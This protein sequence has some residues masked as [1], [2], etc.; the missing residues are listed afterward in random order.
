MKLFM[1]Y[2][3]GAAGNSNIEV[4]DIRFVAGN[5]ITDT[6]QTLRTNWFGHQKGLHID[7]YVEITNIDGYQVSLVAD[8]P[9]TDQRLYFVNL[10]GYKDSSLAE[11]HEFGLFVA[12]NKTEAKQR[13]KE[14]LL[15][16]T[17][18]QHK[19]DLYDVDDCTEISIDNGRYYVQLRKGGEPQPLKPHWYGYKVIGS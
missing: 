13:A 10:G 12:K 3:G 14:S 11:Q 19:D 17:K 4:H 2:L 8:K 9:Q 1:V 7:S 5:E 16:D 18:K 15:M 6:Y